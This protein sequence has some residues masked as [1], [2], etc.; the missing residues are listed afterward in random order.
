MGYVKCGPPY[1]PLKDP[2]RFPNWY[3]TATYRWF[4]GFVKMP[5]LFTDGPVNRISEILLAKVTGCRGK[6][7]PG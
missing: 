6:K 1:V 2:Q 7:N 4:G 3:T 5:F